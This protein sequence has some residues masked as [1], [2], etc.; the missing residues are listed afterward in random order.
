MSLETY[1][2]QD[3]RRPLAAGRPLP[4]PTHATAPLC[5]YF[6]LYPP[7]KNGADYGRFA[8]SPLPFYD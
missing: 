1:L 4:D 8:C 5:R 3:R 7:D 2:A 6:W